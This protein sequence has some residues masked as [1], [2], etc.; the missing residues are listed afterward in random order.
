[1]ARKRN[2]GPTTKRGYATQR[3]LPAGPKRQLTVTL[4]LETARRL[5][6]IAVERDLPVSVVVFDLVERCPIRPAEGGAA[7]P[8][9]GE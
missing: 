1:M 2:G 7:G 6:R 4:P 5:R 3:Q 9:E 8:A